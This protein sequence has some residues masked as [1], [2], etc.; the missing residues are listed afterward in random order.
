MSSILYKDGK[1]EVVSAENVP[2]MLDNGFST[3]DKKPKTKPK[4][5]KEQK[6]DNED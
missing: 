3:E 1:R 6:T 4:A 2:F 5:K